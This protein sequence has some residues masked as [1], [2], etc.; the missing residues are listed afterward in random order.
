MALYLDGDR[1]ALLA[2]RNLKEWNK[3]QEIHIE[4]SSECPDFFPMPVENDA[5]V[6]KWV[7]WSASNTYLIGDFDGNQFVPQ[8]TP[9]RNVFGEIT[10]HRRS[11]T[12]P[13][14]TVAAYRLPG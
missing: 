6:S 7:F 4:G 10:P 14:R 3:L 13:Q 5:G 12:S 9:L 8:S 11:A 1:F 2:S